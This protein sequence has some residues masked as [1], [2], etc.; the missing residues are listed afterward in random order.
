MVTAPSASGFCWH[1][2]SC[3]Q[4]SSSLS[5][6]MLGAGAAKPR[7]CFTDRGPG[8]YNN[9]TGEIVEA[10][11]HA[12]TTNGFRPFAGASGSWQPAD[13]A[14]V[15]PHETV[16]AWVRKWFRKRFS[17]PWRAWR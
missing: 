8:L 10:Y 16:V 11:Y 14:D 15:F 5:D 4:V 3:I 7:V 13:L 17:K 2:L 12:L 1:S 6:G 9:L